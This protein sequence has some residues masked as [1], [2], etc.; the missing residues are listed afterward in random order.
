[1]TYIYGGGGSGD[2]EESQEQR[3]KFKGQL[4][5][6][7]DSISNTL[8]V[9]AGGGLLENVGQIV[10]ALDEAAKPNSA[11]QVIQI[12]S[13]VNPRLLQEKL[14]KIF[15]PKPPQQQPSQK[16]KNKNGEQP[17]QNPGVPQNGAVIIE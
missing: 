8:I 4:S 13:R 1:M 15:G 6:G 16:G 3:I 7:V 11:V 9:S 2:G 12:D 10:E 17:N 5:I 14:H